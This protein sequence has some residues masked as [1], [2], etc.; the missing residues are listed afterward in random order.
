MNTNLCLEE[1]YLKKLPRWGKVVL[2]TFLV[3]V[4][5]FVALFGRTLLDL[6]HVN[7]L[8]TREITQN[9]SAVQTDTVNFFLIRAGS[10]YIAIDAGSDKALAEEGLYE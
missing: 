1:N 4:L 2:T 7:P 6:T 3:I 9:V 5:L 10:G 8:E